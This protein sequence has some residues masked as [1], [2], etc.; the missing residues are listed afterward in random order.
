MKKPLH[1]VSDHAVLRY[2]ERACGVD[3]EAVRREIGYKVALALDHPGA[4]GVIAAGFKFKLQ[5]GVVTTVI[6]V[7]RPDMRLGRV[8]KERG[9]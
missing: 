4:C 1:P 7:T 8:R 9:E 3:V 5:D 6:K 2:L